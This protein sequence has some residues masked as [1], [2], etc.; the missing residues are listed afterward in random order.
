MTSPIDINRD[1]QENKQAMKATADIPVH[2][3]ST[4]LVW[5]KPLHRVWVSK[6]KT[7]LGAVRAL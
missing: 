7:T 4:K 1:R 2:L 3:G 6:E 5:G